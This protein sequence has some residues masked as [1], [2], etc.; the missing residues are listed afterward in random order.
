MIRQIVPAAKLGKLDPRIH[1]LLA[2]ASIEN[3]Q[4]YVIEQ[5]AKAT[6]PGQKPRLKKGGSKS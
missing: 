6:E 3:S 2:G 4:D 5:A 1:S